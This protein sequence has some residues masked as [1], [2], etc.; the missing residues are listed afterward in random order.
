MRKLIILAICSMP[1]LADFFPPTVEVTVS[2]VNGNS[3]ELSPALPVTGM[4][5]ISVHNYG[6][7]I[8]AATSSIMQV[9]DSGKSTILEATLIKKSKLPEIATKIVVGDKVVGGYLYDNVLLL[10]PNERAYN[11]FQSKY[12]KEWI[13]PDLFGVYISR[14]GGEASIDNLEEFAKEYQVGLIAIIMKDSVVLYD[15]ISK[16]IVAKEANILSDTTVNKPFFTRLNTEA[17]GFFGGEIDYNY[18]ETMTKI[19]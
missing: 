14:K 15:P 18:F 7:A 6:G 12:K 5:G 10:A 13:H 9:D 11:S 17:K 4:S 2:N 19:K 16:K 1:L 8:K 3:I